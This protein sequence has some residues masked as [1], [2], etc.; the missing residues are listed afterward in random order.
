MRDPVPSSADVPTS[1]DGRSRHQ[2]RPGRRRSAI[3]RGSLLTLLAVGPWLD[4]QLVGFAI[5]ESFFTLV[6]L[7][8]VNSLRVDR[9]QALVGVLLAGPAMACLWLRQFVPAVGLSQ[10]GL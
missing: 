2:Q 10:A 8:G 6:M 9:R 1:R 5:W 4:E 3:L 7:S